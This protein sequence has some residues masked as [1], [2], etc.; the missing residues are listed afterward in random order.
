M[1]ASGKN[2]RSHVYSDA[3]LHITSLYLARDEFERRL[4]RDRYKPLEADFVKLFVA[5]V[6]THKLDRSEA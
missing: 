6:G 3:G 5:T 2:G 4:R 1:I